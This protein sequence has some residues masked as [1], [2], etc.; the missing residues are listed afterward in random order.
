[1]MTEQRA[2]M[3]EA[4]IYHS[5]LLKRLGSYRETRNEHYDDL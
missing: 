5:S 1:M 2:V 4:F 3:S